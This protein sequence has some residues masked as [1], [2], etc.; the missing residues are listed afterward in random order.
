MFKKKNNEDQPRV[1][2]PQG[3]WKYQSRL[4]LVLPATHDQSREHTCT[5]HRQRTY[6]YT[7]SG[8][9]FSGIEHNHENEWLT[10]LA[11]LPY[12]PQCLNNSLSQLNITKIEYDS[13]LNN[14]QSKW[15]Q[16][17]IAFIIA[18]GYHQFVI[19]YVFLPVPWCALTHWGRDEMDAISQTTCSS[20]FPWMKMFEFWL[21]FH[22]S[23]FLRVQLTIIQHCF[24]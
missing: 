2:F 4:P 5:K 11:M 10:W 12:P 23:L 17:Y 8:Q 7:Y 19:I 6:C 9:S 22:W 16:V 3:D 13:R 24:E 20:A 18:K 1:V 14:Y 21:K 15:F